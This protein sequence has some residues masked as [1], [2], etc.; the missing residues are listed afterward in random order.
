[1][2]LM[3]QSGET[4]HSCFVRVFA[5]CEFDRSLR[6][7]IEIEYELY[8]G[9]RARRCGDDGLMD[10]VQEPAGSFV[11]AAHPALLVLVTLNNE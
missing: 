8:V 2:S 1:M 11:P 10:H 9:Y 6:V 5:M 7:V 3:C 4:P